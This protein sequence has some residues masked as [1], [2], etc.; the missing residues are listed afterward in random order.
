MFF[1]RDTAFSLSEAH[2]RIPDE[3]SLVLW[4]RASQDCLIIPYWDD[5]AEMSLLSF[6]LEL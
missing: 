2:W 3:C 4:N 1:Q 6:Y 5:R